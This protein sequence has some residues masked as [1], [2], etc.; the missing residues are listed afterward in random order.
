MQFGMWDTLFNLLLLLFW[1]EIWDH[2]RKSISIN[3]LLDPVEQIRRTALGAIRPALPFL[4]PRALAG[5]VVVFLVVFRG[6]AL[7]QNVSWTLRL[8]LI[9]TRANGAGL[10]TG[11][12]MS[13][14]SLAVFLFHLWSISLIYVHTRRQAALHN[15]SDAL[16]RISRPFTDIDVVYRPAALL[17]FGMLL[18]WLFT[19]IGSSSTLAPG[20]ANAASL[21]GFLR[22]LILALAG[23]V[24][25]LPM[26]Q[27]LLILL[28][29]G[30]FVSLFTA[31][32]A[33]GAFCR[34]WIDLIVG[35]LR[36]Y[37]LRLGMLD[38]TPLIFMFA[39][40]FVYAFLM[41]ILARAYS[42]LL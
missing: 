29:I 28:I 2:D 21:A 42:A 24:A 40:T 35:P 14:L 32:H 20:T 27:R 10:V 19:H 25:V 39:L 18:A 3:P 37:P 34:E 7:P 8:G 17:G 13:A 16:D 12:Q 31:S 30:S 4:S 9:A 41:G 6:L 22:L 38:L 23:W 15:S 1:T 26:I 11:L 33:L 5:G 36:R